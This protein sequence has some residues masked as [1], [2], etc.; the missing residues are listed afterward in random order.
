[1]TDAGLVTGAE[2]VRKVR[3]LGRRRGVDVTFAAERGRGSHGTLYYGDRLTVVKDRTKEIS[4]GLL[5]A[6][7]DQLGLTRRDLDER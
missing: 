7:L 4:K 5:S 3:R 1:L 2:L 6:M